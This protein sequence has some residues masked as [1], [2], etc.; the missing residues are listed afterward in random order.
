MTNEQLTVFLEYTRRFDQIAQDFPSGSRQAPTQ[1][2]RY[3]QEQKYKNSEQ[4]QHAIVRYFNLCSEEF[5]LRDEG[6]IVD[7]VWQLWRA[8][9][10]IVMRSRVFS[11]LWSEMRLGFDLQPDFQ[12][13][14][15][16]ATN[17]NPAV[18]T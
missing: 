5:Y 13:F 14:V 16:N 9:M 11:L 4:V 2:D 12:Q 10:T 15:D 7:K 8:H 18:V 3:H 1:F 6:L 17:Q